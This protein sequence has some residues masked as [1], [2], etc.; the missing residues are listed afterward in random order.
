M[1]VVAMGPVQ[2]PLK[3]YLRIGE[4]ARLLEVKPHV[5]RFWESEFKSLR[6]RKSSTG[7]RVFSRR[8]VERLTMIKHLLYSQGF[9][10]DGARRHLRARGFEPEEEGSAE[11][12]RPHALR[13]GLLAVRARLVATL[14]TIDAGASAT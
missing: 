3:M 11:V 6:P 1:V 12:T 8:D 7:Q 2:P 9:T 5:I 10:I 14:A 4:V 13:E